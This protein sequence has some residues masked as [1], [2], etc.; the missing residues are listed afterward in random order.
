[1]VAIRVPFAVVAGALFSVAIFVALWQLVNVPMAAYER[2]IHVRPEFTRQIIESPPVTRREPKVTRE[3]PTL[4]PGRPK[5]AD[6]GGLGGTGVIDYRGPALDPVIGRGGLKLHGVDGDVIPLVRP[7][8]DYPPRAISGQIEGWV[9]MRFSVTAAGTV[10]DAIVVASE[11]GTIFN[12]AALKA[13]ARWRYNPRVVDGVAV[14]RVGL[15]T[16]IR[17]ELE[18]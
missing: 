10:R 6:G 14:E 18:N 15:Q 16:V 12:E 13:V 1:M 7:D 2:A 9:Q 17:F 5:I 8:P 11:P 4:Q 3:P